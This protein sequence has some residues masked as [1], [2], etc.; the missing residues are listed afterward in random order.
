MS[1]F[2]TLGMDSSGN[3]LLFPIQVYGTTTTDSS[4]NF[5]FD[6]TNAGLTHAYT[7]QV[8]AKSASNSLANSATAYVSSF[9]TTAVSGHVTLPQNIAILGGSPVQAAGSGLTVYVTVFG[10]Q[11]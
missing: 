6:F 11:N 7:V 5:T 3:L 10:D 8:T 2:E 1:N 4:G 9:S